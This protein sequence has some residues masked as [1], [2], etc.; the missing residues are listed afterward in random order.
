[1]TGPLPASLPGGRRGL[2]RLWFVDTSS[3][4]TMAVHSALGTAVTSYLQSERVVLMKSVWVELRDLKRDAPP[5]T[6]TW[7]G[8]ALTLPWGRALG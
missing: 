8:I 6:A 5:P 2:P 3:L 7:A 4:V 1:M